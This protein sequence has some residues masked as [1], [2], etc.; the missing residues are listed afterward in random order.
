MSVELL[1]TLSLISYII[2]GIFALVATALF[3]LLDIKK[4]IGDVTGATARKAINIIREQNEN[5]RNKEYTLGS[6]SA[7]REKSTDKILSSGRLQPQTA[8]VGDPPETERSNTTKLAPPVEE[9]SVLN[10]ASNE[11]TA[12]N[13]QIGA[14]TALKQ[15]DGSGKN[16]ILSENSDVQA[17]KAKPTYDD[18]KYNFSTDVEM[19]FADSSESIE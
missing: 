4:V 1:Q 7:E 8:G 12:L 15:N 11:T 9:T 16:A 2:A 3:F 19:G 17:Q 18:H 6:I 10:S 13:E 5:S 14:T